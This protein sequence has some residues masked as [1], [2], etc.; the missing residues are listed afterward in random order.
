MFTFFVLPTSDSYKRYG[1]TLLRCYG[2]CRMRG[3]KKE[4]NTVTP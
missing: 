1:V 4:R 3:E 2:E